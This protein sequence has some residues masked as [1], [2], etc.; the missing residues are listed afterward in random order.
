MRDSETKIDEV[1]IL[2]ALLLSRPIKRDRIG[3][4]TIAKEIVAGDP[5]VAPARRREG[6]SPGA[7]ES[8]PVVR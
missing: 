4:T 3:I 1:R 6:A 8:R 7:V 5:G 2:A